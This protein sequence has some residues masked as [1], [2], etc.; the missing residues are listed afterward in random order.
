LGFIEYSLYVF[1]FN[2]SLPLKILQGTL[3]HLGSD[4]LIVN[5]LV[6]VEESLQIRIYSGI[7]RLNNRCVLLFLKATSH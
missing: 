5:D 1:Q 7:L 3:G 2:L 4:Y 6:N